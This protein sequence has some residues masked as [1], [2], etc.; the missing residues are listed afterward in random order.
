MAGNKH[1]RPDPSKLLKTKLDNLSRLLQSSIRSNQFSTKEEYLLESVRMLGSFY[2]DLNEPIFQIPTIRHDDVP[3]PELYTNLWQNLLDDLIVIFTELENIESL[4]LANFNFITTETN[5]LTSR[6]K[7][8][9]SKLGDYILYSSNPSK[10]AIFF[11][12]SFSDVSKIEVDSSLL[13]AD[14]CNIDQAQG[15][16]TLPID[17]NQESRIAIKQIPIINP[18]SN[19]VPGNNQEIGKSYNGDLG[20]IIDNNPDTWYEYENVVLPTST[21]R[22]PLVLDLV[23]NLGSETPINFI[24]IN[25][26][27]FGTKSVIKINKIET[28]FDGEIYT[29]IMN[30]IPNA[31][32]IGETLESQFTLA[33]STSKFAGQ[34]LYS[35]SP[36]KV[37]YIHI[38]LQQDEPYVITTSSGD[39]LRYAIGIRGIEIRGFRY[40]STGEL[41]SKEFESSDEIRKVLVNANQF[42]V[43][44]S[45]LATIKYYL[46]PDGGST[47]HQ[48]RPQEVNA[49][50]GAV[51]IPNILEFNGASSST[52]TTPAPVTKIRTKIVLSRTDDNFLDETSSFQKTT[53]TASEIHEIP[54]NSPFTISLEHPPVN[55]TVLLIDPMF[56]SRGKPELPYFVGFSGSQISQQKYRLPFTTLPRPYEKKEDGGIYYTEQVTS[57][58]WMHVEVEGEE[59]QHITTS[60][61]SYSSSDKVYSVNTNTGELI[62]G[63]DTNGMTPPADS[64]I[65]LYFDAERLFPSEIEDNHVAKLEFTSSSNKDTVLIQ[66]FAPDEAITEEVIPKRS[67][68]TRLNNKNI[69]VYSGIN[70]VFPEENEVAFINGRDEISSPGDWSID[71]DNG[72]VYSYTPTSAVSDQTVGYTYKPVFDLTTDDWDWA[73]TALMRDSISIKESA[74]KTISV[75]EEALPVTESTYTVDLENLAVVKGSVSLVVEANGSSLDVTS[76]IHP[77]VKEVPFVDGVSEFQKEDSGLF[78]VDYNIGKIFV[79][80]PF[81]ADI[82]SIKVNYEYTDYRCKY[83]ISRLVDPKAYSVDIT[84]HTVTLKDSEVVRRAMMP[85][86]RPDNREPYYMI[87]YD[88]IVES[89]EDA[90]ELQPLYSPVVK[91]YALKVLTKGRIF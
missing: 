15:I 19:G 88:Y 22:T 67:T 50:S 1:L 81:N 57:S 62:F 33:P 8:V 12:D 28:S 85:H 48:I 89:R 74:W 20:T 71:T 14:Q 53:G 63:N 80:R 17:T 77:F 38:V 7:S 29:S 47:W 83:N 65:T 4:T 27:N 55:G 49:T 39:R 73:T 75:N 26:N 6:L 52:I 72:I 11:K 43:Q 79:Q 18:N 87:T 10:D 70:P 64:L 82:T 59:W 54:R 5:R 66:R 46:S 69:Q 60:W 13:N 24:R 25:P 32:F 91:D 35:F 42:P 31:D 68:I 37:K 45:E 3:D 40:L 16:I 86:K 51:N 41:A 44:A 36:R 78:S 84:N 76:G 58:G 61:S 30:D 2:K 34:G 56:G 23:I 21:V 90:A 9:S